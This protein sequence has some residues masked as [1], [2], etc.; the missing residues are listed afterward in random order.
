[1]LSGGRDRD[2]AFWNPAKGETGPEELKQ[3]KG[4]PDK[5]K[6]EMPGILA[7]AVEPGDCILFDGRTLHSTDRNET[8]RDQRRFSA[9]FIDESAIYTPRADYPLGDGKANAKLEPGT[10]SFSVRGDQEN[11]RFPIF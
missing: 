8:D 11:L 3:D 10:R 4:L 7:W 6:T 9:R 5:L 2:R 1:M